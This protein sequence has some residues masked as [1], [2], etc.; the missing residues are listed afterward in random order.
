M[1]AQQGSL[2]NKIDFFWAY[3]KNPCRPCLSDYHLAPNIAQRSHGTIPATPLTPAALPKTPK[4]DKKRTNTVNT[5][6]MN[7]PVWPCV[8]HKA[9][10]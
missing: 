8:E 4:G 10:R 9:Q 2:S 6:G 7:A 1:T 3:L 5:D